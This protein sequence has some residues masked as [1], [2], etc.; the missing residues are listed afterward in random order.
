LRE[1]GEKEAKGGCENIADARDGD[2]RT[3]PRDHDVMTFNE[4][5][6]DTAILPQMRLLDWVMT[7]CFIQSIVTLLSRALKLVL[8]T[9]KL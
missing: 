4:H 2:E 1:V 7:K 6:C 8:L 3:R 9:E 5:A